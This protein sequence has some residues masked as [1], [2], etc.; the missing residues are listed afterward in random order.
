MF[1]LKNF[2]AIEFESKNIWVQKILGPQKFWVTKNFVSK[3]IWVQKNLGP[4]IFGSKIFDPKI[5]GEKIVLGPNDF[6]F[7][8]FFGLQKN[9][10]HTNL[11]LRKFWSQK[12]R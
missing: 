7:Q 12:L 8:K 5:F 2:G 6:C 1:G 3:K 10:G 4:E 9:L 11:G